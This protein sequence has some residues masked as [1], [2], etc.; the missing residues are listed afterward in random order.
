MKSSRAA[1]LMPPTMKT[2]KAM[3]RYLMERRGMSSQRG[4]TRLRPKSLRPA[5]QRYSERVPTGQSQPQKARLSSRL[6]ARKMRNRTMA[7]G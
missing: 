2:K 5:F 3:S 4:S 6:M 7:A 1:A